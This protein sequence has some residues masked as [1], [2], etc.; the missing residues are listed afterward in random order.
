[1]RG[2]GPDRRLKIFSD[3]KAL[4]RIFGHTCTPTSTP[5]H[6][7]LRL[8]KLAVE[9]AADPVLQIPFPAT[10]APDG[11][12]NVEISPIALQQTVQR[13]SPSGTAEGARR[14]RDDTRRKR[15]HGRA[16]TASVPAGLVAA[17]RGGGRRAARSSTSSA[18][19]RLLPD[20]DAPPAGATATTTPRLHDLRPR[21]GKRYRAYR[22]V[23]FQGDIGQ[24]YGI[25]GTSWKAPPILDDPTRLDTLGGRTYELFY[26]GSRM[27]MV[28]WHTPKARLLGLQH[29]LR[30]L[31][32]KQMLAIA[33][34]AHRVRRAGA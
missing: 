6:A 5:T 8:L 3:R 22:I 13:S 20:A 23:V 12:G 7:I 19:A 2:Q 32:N 14:R 28:A 1:M 10:D 24:Y 26:D 11:S 9:S 29:A 18:V 21:N 33:R 4:L 34:S 27:R 16:R 17:S 30:S 25:Q 15:K 31:T